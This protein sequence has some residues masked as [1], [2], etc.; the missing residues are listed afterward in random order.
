MCSVDLAS[1]CLEFNLKYQLDK[2]CYFSLQSMIKKTVKIVNLHISNRYCQ[3]KSC[4]ISPT[5][6]DLLTG[7]DT[8][9]GIRNVWRDPT[10]VTR[11]PVDLAPPAHLT[12]GL[13]LAEYGERS[14]PCNP[15]P[16]R[17]GTTCTANTVY[18]RLGLVE[19]KERPDPCNPS[20]CGPGTTCTPN[21]LG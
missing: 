20:P 21:R 4:C 19:Y 9:A 1:I 2:Q 8:Y 11:H 15:S 17:L 16:C 6:S 7:L 18:S 12:G 5:Y 3:A 14:D 13:G 10:L